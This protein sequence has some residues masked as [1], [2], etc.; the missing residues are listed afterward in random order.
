MTRNK[1]NNI[2]ENLTGSLNENNRK[3]TYLIFVFARK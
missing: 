2:E 3:I 1:Y